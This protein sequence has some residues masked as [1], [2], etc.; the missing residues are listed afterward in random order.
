MTWWP[1]AF[2]TLLA[3]ASAP[4]AAS[5]PAALAQT[6]RPA[7]HAD[8]PPPV[9]PR[10][11]HVD[12]IHGY[13]RSDDYF[14]LRDKT[15]PDVIAYLNAENAYGAELLAPMQPLRDTLF[16]EMLRRIQQT[17]LSV[18]YRDGEYLYYSRTE[19]GR[20]YPIY[21]RKRGSLE[22]PE[23]VLLD[24]NQLAVGQ[25]FMGLGT[26]QVSD[27]GN[28]LAYS[29]DTTGFR[30]YALRV[31]DLRAGRDLPDRAYRT[32]SV[33]WAADNH[34]LFYTIEDAAKRHYRVYRHSLGASSDDLVYEETDE[35]FGV[36]V[37]RTRSGEYLV[38]DVGSHTTSEVRTLPAS[39]PMGEWR[40][41]S[42]RRQDREYDV[43]HH[44]DRF[45]IHV[46]DTGRNFRLV[47]APVSDP[48]EANWHE[49]VP[50]RADVMLE[51][52]DFFANHYLLYERQNG[53]QRMRVTDLR[54]GASH[55]LGFPEPVYTAFGSTNRQW[56]TTVFRYSYQSFITP[57]SVY[58]YDMATR[59][60][61]LLK[62]TE[63][64]GGYDPRNYVSE[65]VYATA[66]DGV[67][68]P[69]SLVYRRGLRRDGRAPMLLNAYGSYGSSSNVTFNSNRLSL[70]DRGM[71]FAL[72][73]I[74]GGGEMGKA[75]HDDGRML[76]KMNTFTDFIASG[77]YLIAQHY[78][79]S[80]RLVIQGGSAGGLLM[81]AVTNLRPDLF[82]AVVANVPFVDVINT[83]LDASLPLTVGEFEEWG[84]PRIREQYDYMIQYSPYD[85]IAAR[86]Y[87]TMLV[88]TSLNDSQ[89]LF[90]EPTKYVA[91]MR[92]MRT[93]HN[94]LIFTI[95]MGAGH[96][97]ASG[98][99]DRLREIAR[100]Y[101][102]V[103]WEAGVREVTAPSPRLTPP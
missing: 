22:A 43:D 13:V 84:N 47:W 92:S 20:Q 18:P 50:H 61:T 73:H 26:F 32:G 67:R 8:T 55:Y 79:A 68:I 97:G 103:L 44:G 11:V 96:G 91:R 39:Q 62:Q 86:D 30:Q 3:L 93:D 60:R 99:Y 29:L 40:L 36:S 48:G 35:R 59:R 45:Y 69:I 57:S 89:V 56:N 82:H 24:L 49:I 16:A 90:H 37:S 74:R 102:F 33:A 88:T 7:A 25:V 95:N 31:K 66:S 72:A 10:R 83:M 58:D 65:R 19:E 70:L 2:A 94:P 51:G 63:V 87:P 1:R 46:N 75:W 101:A 9:A 17:D 5:G 77:E 78:T 4:L 34:T 81:G 76:H 38:M 64:L 54:S 12:T 71:V 85:N 80:E 15:N 14:W 98:R 21:C 53:L 52:M 42:P 27:D 6:P 28:L 23:E 41:I 100:D